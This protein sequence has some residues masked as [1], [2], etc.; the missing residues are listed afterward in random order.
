MQLQQL[1]TT[2]AAAYAQKGDALALPSTIILLIRR[3]S[4]IFL[5]SARAN[6]CSLC[7]EK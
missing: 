2:A 6:S 1:E 7:Q 5:M 4:L 3:A